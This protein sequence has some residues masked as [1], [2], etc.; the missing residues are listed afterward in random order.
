MIFAT[1]LAFANHLGTPCKAMGTEP[2][3]SGSQASDGE[4]T[5]DEQLERRLAAKAEIDKETAGETSDMLT[6]TERE[7]QRVGSKLAPAIDAEKQEGHEQQVD[8]KSRAPKEMKRK[9]GKH[10]KRHKDKEHEP[11][12]DE[13]PMAPK[14]KK[15]KEA[16]HKKHHKDKKHDEKKHTCKKDKKDHMTINRVRRREFGQKPGSQVLPSTRLLFSV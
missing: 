10:K 7:Q 16:K 13:K 11:Q 4:A 12:A 3:W 5:Q 9:D 14:E 8:E 2:A 1:F 15:H 6:A